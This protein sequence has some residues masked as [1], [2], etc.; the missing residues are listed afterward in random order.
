MAWPSK[1]TIKDI[2]GMEEDEFKTKLGSAE[3]A[4]NKV[5]ELDQKFSSFAEEIK[6]GLAALQARPNNEPPKQDPPANPN[7]GEEKLPS[8]FENED[9]AFEARMKKYLGPVAEATVLTRAEMSFNNVKSSIKDFNLFEEEIKAELAKSPLQYR[10]N[11]DYIK[12]CYHMVKGRHADEI[13]E[14]NSKKSGKYFIEGAST[15]GNNI[16]N[17]PDPNKVVL[18]EDELKYAAKFGVKPEDYAKVKG[19]LKYV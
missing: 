1:P 15:S 6:A 3:E 5:N 2:L 17:S 7:P 18:T 11:E 19:S 8:F 14:H 9:A 10:A 16:P 12:N 4:K 13:L